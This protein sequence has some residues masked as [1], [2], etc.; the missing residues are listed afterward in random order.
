MK[1]NTMLDSSQAH[2]RDSQ[3]ITGDG[4]IERRALSSTVP[5]PKAAS[6]T[7]SAIATFAL[8]GMIIYILCQILADRTVTHL[9]RL[10]ATHTAEDLAAH[11]IEK[12]PDLNTAVAG[13]LL[14]VTE[15]TNLS[16]LQPSKGPVNFVILDPRGMPWA[17]TAAQN[18]S[19]AGA[20]INQRASLAK[21]AIETGKS[22]LT[23]ATRYDQPEH[24]ATVYT[25]IIG[26]GQVVA[27]MEVGIDQTQ[28]Y[29]AYR[30]HAVAF[31]SAVAIA[32]A[33][34]FALPA[35]FAYV[36]SRRIGRANRQ[37]RHFAA[38]DA[39]SA[40]PNRGQFHEAIDLALKHAEFGAKAG[41]MMIGPAGYAG[42]VERYGKG[43]GDEL[44]KQFAARLKLNVRN[45]DMVARIGQE[46][47][48]VVQRLIRSSQDCEAMINRLRAILLQPYDVRGQVVRIGID[49]GI[50]LLPGNAIG[51][52]AVM[53]AA[54]LSMQQSQSKPELKMALV[55]PPSVLVSN[56]L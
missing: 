13:R 25:P 17:E 43:V 23:G 11:L 3:I 9:L 49:V 18:A 2:L 28:R 30:A 15:R 27:V 16:A 37:I 55:A 29:A 24:F 48:G 20:A 44:L 56:G 53:K 46:H 12:I 52:S 35:L 10:D 22:F 1:V 26:R 41:V 14:T 21:S 19:V 42:I 33:L 45:G 50:A 8:A 34:A 47:F 36:L 38:H 31:S 40:L 51:P 32:I 54:E 4:L 7:R 39:L 5:A 6:S